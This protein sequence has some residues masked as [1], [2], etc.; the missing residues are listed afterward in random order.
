MRHV[1]A[2]G[3]AILLSTG[4]S[5]QAETS[6][7]RGRYLMQGIVACGNCHTPM[8]PNG[9]EFERELAGGLEFKEQPFTAYAPNI[10]PDPETGIGR[11]SDEQIILAIREGKRPDGS[12]IGPP[13]P[14]G[15]Y[16][17]ISDSD[18]RAIVAYLRAAKPVRN[19][20]P[21]SVYRIPLPPH[22]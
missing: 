22:Y 7:E 6:L 19:P 16:R 11:W 17:G 5:V 1:A 21:K 15:L 12:I 20:V 18:A 8:G 10:T 3:V 14:I 9:P 4:S 2:I 13:M